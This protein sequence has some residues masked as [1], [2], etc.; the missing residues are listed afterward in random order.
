MGR[1]H[2]TGKM[3][4][5]EPISPALANAFGRMVFG[6][7]AGDWTPSDPGQPQVS[8]DRGKAYDY[9]ALCNLVESF[10]EPLPDHVLVVLVA[11]IH[12]G[13]E[14]LKADLL[15]KKSYSSAARVL[16]LLMQRRKDEL[17][18]LEEL[19]KEMRKARE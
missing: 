13:N 1:Q 6:Y 10:D 3:S 18:K 14:D 11:Q 4:A 9:E 15:A 12:F 16:R 19:R 5:E 7:A 17:R 2:R 8:I